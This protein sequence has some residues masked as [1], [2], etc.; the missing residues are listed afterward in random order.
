VIG[1]ECPGRRFNNI[2][3]ITITGKEDA[4]TYEKYVRHSLQIQYE[5]ISLRSAQL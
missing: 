5:E 1:P 3:G 2:L 4:H